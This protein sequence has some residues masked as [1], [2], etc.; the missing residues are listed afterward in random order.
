MNLF[1]YQIEAVNDLR[2]SYVAGAK[3]PLLVLPTG[4][5]KT[6]CFTYMT[7]EALKKGRRVLLLAQ[8]R[9]LVSQISAAL[10]A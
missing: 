4:G 5:G 7:S 3:A 1:D 6:V 2:R 9:E 8:R 10:K